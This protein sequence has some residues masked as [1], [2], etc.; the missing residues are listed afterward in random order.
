[1]KKIMCEFF[2]KSALHPWEPDKDCCDNCEADIYYL[3]GMD[4]AFQI[5]IFLSQYMERVH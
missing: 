5:R 1:M 3:C 2:M 4:F